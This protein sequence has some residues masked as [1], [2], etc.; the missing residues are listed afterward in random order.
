MAMRT[1]HADDVADDAAD[2]AE[3]D[4]AECTSDNSSYLPILLGL[5][6]RLEIISCLIILANLI[7][8]TDFFFQ[9]ERKDSD[10]SSCSSGVMDTDA[11]VPDHRTFNKKV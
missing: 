10:R 2:D 7:I 5:G 6:R 3:E 4:A 1:V 9:D 11:V 8:L